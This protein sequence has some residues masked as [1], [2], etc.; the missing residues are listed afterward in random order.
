MNH[1]TLGL[2][3][4]HQLPESAQ[5]HVHWVGDAIQPSHPLSST[6]PPALN[7]SQ[8]QGL[9]QWVSSSHQVAKY[10]SFSLLYLCKLTGQCYWK[11]NLFCKQSSPTV[12]IFDKYTS[13]DKT[14]ISVESIRHICGH[15]ILLLVIVLRF[16]CLPVN[17]TGSWIL[18]VPSNISLPLSKLIFLIF[19]PNL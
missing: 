9:F 5:T 16:C 15:Q 8:Y 4:H 17:E 10:W 2:P 13:G 12:V 18:L 3:V 7:L 1:S 6:S 11:L 14:Y 19:S